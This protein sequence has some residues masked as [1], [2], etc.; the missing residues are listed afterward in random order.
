[1]D[2]LLQDVRYA[3]RMIRQRPWV[4]AVVLVTLA[5]GIG[6]NTAIFS[7]VNAIL[8]KPLPYPAAD[9]IVGL[10]ERRPTGQSNSMSTLNYLDYA[11]SDVF[12][13]V[14]ATAICCSATMLD[15]G[16]TPTPLAGLKVS[17]PYFDV[18]GAKAQLGRTFAA[19]EDQPGRNRVVVLSHRLW[20]SRFGSDPGLVGRTIRLD[21]QPYTVIGVMPANSPFDRSFIELWLPIPLD[22]HMNRS[23]HWMLTLTGGGIGLLKPGVTVERARAELGAIAARLAREHPDTNKGWGVTLDRYSDIVAR[24]DLRPSLYLMMAAVATVLLIA[25]VNV[26]NMKLAWALARDRE[27][28]VRLALGA[29]PRRLVRQFLTESLLISGVGG[30]LGIFVGGVAMTALRRILTALPASVANLP[31]VIPPDAT[32]QLDV[33]VLAFA[34]TVSVACGVL[35][36]LAPA[37]TML[38]STRTALA[39]GPRAGTPLT[40]RRVQRGLIVAQIALAFVLL[41][42]A[43][44]LIR[45]L[46]RM[47]EADVGF[48]A[49][50]V[51]T[52]QL[53]FSE[54]H[55]AT[56]DALRAFMHEAIARVRAIP[57]VGDAAFIDG[58]PMNGAPRG[59]FVQRADQPV[60]ERAQRPVADLK[61]VGA[62]YFS[63]LGLHLRR[64]RTLSELDRASS[65]LVAVMNETM[66]HT[67]FGDAN[68]VGQRLVMDAPR[69]ADGV[70]A[71]YEVVGV[72]ADERLTPFDDHQPHAVMYVSNEQDP[73]DFHGLIVRTSLDATRFRTAIVAAIADVDAGIAVS[74]ITTVDQ[75]ISESMTP[76]R[77]RSTL[78]AVFAAV[79]LL[80]SAIGIYGVV[81]YSVAQ[82]T[83]EIGIRAALGATR[84]HLIELVVGQGAV[85]V[86]AGL[87]VGAVL[88]LAVARLL[89]SL[90]FGVTTTDT[91]TWS[92]TVSVVAV[93]ALLASYIPARDAARVDPLEA[94][95]VD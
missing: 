33:R 22:Q 57:G 78:L 86:A 19:G 54:S 17:A 29:E 43:G 14:A 30:V 24:E 18:F 7:F 42:N 90:L 49:A 77:F 68:P 9:R 1:V 11:A 26:A 51:L 35:F 64:G 60:V 41:A 10:W 63:V 67:Y 6:A 8:L 89:R 93:M 91:A 3:V 31:I 58:M 40:H 69:G 47:G 95:R 45:S 48:E 88:A 73:Q 71:S 20:V 4:T 38:R 74:H 75:L 59:T 65:P 61:I 62:G 23:N 52:A 82:R 85:L 28:A 44:L 13:H 72:I 55:F 12:E 70:T 80:L 53:G 94:L 50:H 37:L 79:A 87:A 46:Q 76:D 39:G 36:G 56:P 83:H 27:V 84:A 15:D 2:L 34:V 32:V 25:C 21:N 81:A 5:I 66:A 16:P 92:V